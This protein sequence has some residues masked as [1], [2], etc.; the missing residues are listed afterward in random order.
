MKIR[1]FIYSFFCL[2]AMSMGSWAQDIKLDDITKIQFV[3]YGSFTS[4]F[5]RVTEVLPEGKAWKCYQLRR[6]EER[7]KF[8]KDSTRRFVK[9]ISL[10]NLNQLLKYIN[11][12]DT[13]V[14]LKQFKISNTELKQ[15]VDTLQKEEKPEFEYAKKAN[16]SSRRGDSIAANLTD[17][18]KV[19]FKKIIDA[20]LAV[21][22]ASS[23]ALHPMSWD[24]AHYYWIIFTHKN[25]LTDTIEAYQKP[26]IL[27]HLP[28]RIKNKKSYNPH[29]TELFESMN[30][31][32][33]FIKTEQASLNYRIDLEIFQRWVATPAFWEDYIR[34]HPTNYALLNKTLMPASLSSNGGSGFLKSS[35]L[36]ANVQLSFGFYYAPNDT[37]N[38]NYNNTEEKQLVD[39]YHK[40]SFLL[41][42]LK[43]NPNDIA[44]TERASADI[45]NQIKTIYP[46]I[47]QYD[48]KQIHLLSVWPDMYRSSL[49]DLSLWLLLPD[50]AAILIRFSD[51]M[52]SRGDKIFAG[53]KSTKSTHNVCLVFDNDGKRIFG[54]ESEF[55][56]KLP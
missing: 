29:L 20:G 56:I 6:Y 52:I 33:D 49:L 36:P 5:V 11:H 34:R 24:D 35:L 16:M 12:P 21:S 9:T 25:N 17:E 27:Y 19:Y 37:L 31:N 30:A 43:A 53:F 15:W 55:K 46:A 10:K 40:G 42:Y 13:L 54:D 51:G 41:D 8:I 7:P 1:I 23:K 38:A 50:G 3:H 18:Q 47:A 26:F 32:N 2:M 48:L 4:P 28:W 22:D 14:N 44:I 45:I 39:V